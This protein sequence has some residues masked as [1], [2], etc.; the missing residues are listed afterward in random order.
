MRSFA[1][2]LIFEVSLLLASKNCAWGTRFNHRTRGPKNE[3]RV[4]R[5]PRPR[6]QQIC[7]KRHDMRILPGNYTSW[8][9][10]MARRAHM[11]KLWAWHI[12]DCKTELLCPRSRQKRPTRCLFF[13]SRVR[14]M[15]RVPHA[16]FFDASNHLTSKIKMVAKLRMGYSFWLVQEVLNACCGNGAVGGGVAHTIA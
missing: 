4:G 1:T 11:L 13:G 12:D 7:L 14:R 8:F 6:T 16:Q 2:I 10:C 5:L 9:S 3:H 15:N